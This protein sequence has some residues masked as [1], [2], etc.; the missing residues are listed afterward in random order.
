[1]SKGI[2]M[3]SAKDRQG[4]AYT[5][6]G[7]QRL[8]DGL[9]TAPDLFCDDPVCGCPVRFVPRYQQNRSNRIEPVDVPAYIGLIRGSAHSAGCRFNAPGQLK[10]IAAQ[11]DPEFLSALEDGKRELRLLALHNGLHR[12]GLSGNVPAMKGAELNASAAKTA[13]EVVAS[14]KK[15]DSYLRTTADLLA[16]RAM[17]ESD[18]LLASELILRLGP[19]RIPWNQFFFEQDRFDEAWEQVA[20]GGSHPYPVA[21]VG[22]VR[23]FYQP[24][25]DAKYKSSFLNCRSLYRKTDDPHRIESFEVSIAHTDATWLRSFMPGTEIVLF[26]L[27]K[28]SGPAENS[29]PDKRDRTRA[30]TYVAHKLTLTP[31]FKKQIVIVT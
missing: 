17:C 23:S 29:A 25:A 16:L 12:Q 31:K 18:A 7:L 5:L 28:A 15:L 30:T 3:R 13:T 22:S 20:Q 6:E 19:K 21:L 27:L 10:I 14:D 8:A 2:K 11:S 1:M 24:P 26:G 9:G 4:H